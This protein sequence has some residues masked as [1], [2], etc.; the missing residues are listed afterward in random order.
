MQTSPP[1]PTAVSLSRRCPNCKELYPYT[2]PHTCAATA[3]TLYGGAAE[4]AVSGPGARSALSSGPAPDRLA[5]SRALAVTAVGEMSGTEPG[6]PLMPVQINVSAGNDDLLGAIIG[7]RYEI[8]S[9]LDHGGMGVVYKA[10]HTV[11]ENFLAVKILLRPQDEEAQRRFLLEAKLASKINHPNTVHLS[12]FGVLEDGRSYL[13]MEL[14]RGPTL[15]KVLSDG[16]LDPLRACRIAV[17]IARGLCAVHGAGIVHR[18][19]NNLP[20]SDGKF[21]ASG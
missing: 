11:L 20:I 3:E 10:R 6:M 15:A 18:A 7:E 1:P 19:F 9:R 12:D 21:R 16:R 8:L 13:V 4:K 5:E 14:L 17:Q 2:A